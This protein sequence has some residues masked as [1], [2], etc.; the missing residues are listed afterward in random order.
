MEYDYYKEKN[1][2]NFTGWLVTI[3]TIFS[4]LLVIGLIFGILTEYLQIKEIG[5][6]YTSV[7]WINF[8]V[9]IATQIVSL[10]IVFAVILIATLVLR[11]NLLSK[12]QSLFFLKKTLPIVLLTFIFS[13]FAS[14]LIKETVYNRFLLFAN[15][16]PFNQ[17]DPI[18]NQDL[19]YY[20]FQRPFLISLIGSFSFVWLIQTFYVFALYAVFY[21]S[22][23][24]RTFRDLMNE[25]GIII[26]NIVNVVIY[27]LIKAGTYKFMSEDI[28]YST[29][30]EVMGA[31]YTDVTV[32]LSYYKIAPLLLTFIVALTIFFVLR[33]KIKQAIVSVAIF[34]I[35]WTVVLL[36]SAVVQGLIVTPNEAAVE[37]PY[38]K[39]NIEYT[40]DAYN[41][42]NI[43]EK[44]FPVSNNLTLEDI[45][46][47]SQTINNIRITDY[48][49]TLTI[50]NQLQGIRNYYRFE[51]TDVATYNINGTPTAVFTGGRELDKDKIPGTK[52]YINMKQ[53]YTHGFG[54]VMNPVNRITTQGHPEFI[55]KDIPPK[56]I[57]GAPE[58]TQPRIY[59]GELTNDY[60]IVNSKIKELDYYE[61][62]EEIDFS[63]DG[64]A[65]IKL[66]FF[67]R[68]IFAFKYGDIRMLVSSSITADSKLMFNRNV[69]ERVQKV[70]PFLRYDNDPYIVITDDGKLKWVVDIYTT[71]EYYPYSQPYGD[72]NTTSEYYPY[73]QPYG[74]INYVRNSAKA[75][76]DAYDGTVEFYITD[77]TDPIINVYNKIYPK[78]FNIDSLPADIA[79]HVRYPQSMFKIQTA[80]F[81]RYHMTNPMAFYHKTDYWNISKEMY[82]GQS[83]DVEPYYNLMKL[84]GIEGQEEL[85]LMIPYTLSEKDNMVAWLAVRSEGEQYGKMV[86]YKFPKGKNV[87]GTM[88]IESRIDQKPD[89]SSDMTLWGQGGSKVIRGNL[90]VIPIE[91]SILYV[92]P[93]YISA[94]NESSLPEMKRVVVAYDEQIVMERTLDDALK[95]IFGTKRPVIPETGE[96]VQ[97]LIERALITFENYKISLQENEW[98]SSGKT[99][100][101]LDDVMQILNDKKSEINP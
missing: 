90:L 83:R 86:L 25:K 2:K 57:E 37:E 23:G 36:A 78:L 50:L 33:G 91:D 77:N 79:V 12:N 85:V 47:N 24:T 44:E 94:D 34:P 82:S 93:V 84:P 28:L 69:L 65:G 54:V 15:S 4:L 18:F 64:E 40:R 6:K 3:L 96:D 62:N 46:Q 41:L 29:I 49:A 48:P 16:I 97:S 92:E 53:R 42:N 5:E 39:H 11:K 13:F 1:K 56:S 59:F 87:Y 21:V 38:L 89:I 72:I 75:I 35:T 63:Y 7:F 30:G 17:S 67:N 31:G 73:S 99:L 71:S 26:H 9:K 19:G 52:T 22:S 20:I 88:Q 81:K 66:G 101:E 95:A 98:E 8:N 27:F 80:I 43:I 58:I 74:D 61:G 14:S 68:L 32:W 45:A 10:I 76:V 100:K 55:I 70:A 60:V 51:D